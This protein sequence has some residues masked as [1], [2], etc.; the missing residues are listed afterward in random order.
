MKRDFKPTS[1][2]VRLRN[3]THQAYSDAIAAARTC[4]SMDV[5]ESKDVTAK[6]KDYIGPLTFDAGHHTVYQHATFEFSLENVSRHFVW[7]VLH[8]FPYYNSDQQ[9]QR[10]VR[11]N[12]LRAFTP[13]VEGDVL[14]LYQKA[15]VRQ[16]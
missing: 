8:S 6:Q 16:T 13:P 15:I 14:D 7:S 10:Y 11:L 4:Y 3:Y 9:S 5:I 1:P 2:I 12:D